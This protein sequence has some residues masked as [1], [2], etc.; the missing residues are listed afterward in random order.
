MR[1]DRNKEC[2]EH[3]YEIIA[4]ML[5]YFKEINIDKKSSDKQMHELRD[6][7]NNTTQKLEELTKKHEETQNQ[8]SSLVTASEALKKNYEECRTKRLIGDIQSINS[9]AITNGVPSTCEERQ[10]YTG[11]LLMQLQ[12]QKPFLISCDATVEGSG[13]TVIQ[14]RK[15]GLVDF[16]LKWAQYK[17]GFGN[18]ETEFFIGLDRLHRLTKGERY[19]LYIQLI[20]QS[21]EISYARYDNFVIE[22]EQED[23]RL[24]S[25]GQYTGN[26]GDSL[27]VH[28]GNKFST[29]DRDHDT[30]SNRKCAVDQKGAWWYTDCGQR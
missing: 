10:N 5:D 28:V 11:T 25:V 27:S 29:K 6:Q 21:N 7:L 8:L 22:S 17:A 9:Q 30:D 18:V 23:Y 3:S 19:E 1:K 4:P 20:D 24:S 14:R 13:W 12:D 16:Y 15:A 2:G 26:A